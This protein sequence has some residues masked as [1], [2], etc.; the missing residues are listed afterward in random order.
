MPTIVESLAQMDTSRQRWSRVG[1]LWPQGPVTGRSAQPLALADYVPLLQV[2]ETAGTEDRA[3]RLRALRR[4][5][6]GRD[7]RWAEGRRRG[8][9]LDA[10]LAGAAHD[11]PLAWSARPG[12]LNPATVDALHR[13]GYLLPAPPGALPLDTGAVLA[14]LETAFSGGSD[15]AL[16][17]ELAVGVP[18]EGTAGWAGDLAAWLLEWE[19]LR[20]AAEAA[21]TPW[22]DAVAAA[23]LAA[24]Q[25]ERVPLELLL[26]AM[27]GRVLGAHLETTV[28]DD[29]QA[30]PTAAATLEAYYGAAVPAEHPHVSTRFAAFVA[31]ARPEIPHTGEG[32]AVVLSDDAG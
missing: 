19:R 27:D 20:A 22:N 4:L 13:A 7:V 12:G 30:A 29:V 5:Y 8:T 32:A 25:A 9:R 16:G 10:L 24:V 31:A 1:E 18:A 15:L 2:A 17:A 21:R 6:Y 3:R 23:R 14:G 26:G 11:P 28:K